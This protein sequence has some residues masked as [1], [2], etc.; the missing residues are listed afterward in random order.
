MSGERNTC[1]V[2]IP[3]LNEEQAIGRVLADLPP[4]LARQIIVVDNG[5]VDRTAEMARDLGARVIYEP[6]RG[7]GAACLAGINA[8]RSNPP[9]TVLFIDGDYS[10]DPKQAWSIVTPVLS[11]E[12]DLVLGSRLSG[13][14]QKGAMPPHAVF[15]NQFATRIMNAVWRSHYTDLGPFRAINW[16]ALELLDMQDRGYGW[17]IEMQIK[18]ARLR[19]RVREVPVSYR[20]RV[21]ESKISGTVRGS[22]KAGAKILATIA[23]HGFDL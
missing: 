4:D 5:S 6:M 23:R 20:K 22:V 7:Y 17:T 8:I 2:I 16:R 19:L 9:H 13:Q 3:A 18:A 15:G 12:M 14:L 11:G 1:D 10:D 21:G